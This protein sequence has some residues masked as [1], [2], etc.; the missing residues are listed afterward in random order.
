[1]K[2]IAVVGSYNASETIRVSRIP[3]PGETVMGTGYS[4]GPGGKGSNQAVAARRLDGEVRFV[5]CVGEDKDGDEALSLWRSEKVVV[6]GVR[7]VGRHTGT[8]LIVVK[9]DT[10]ANIITIDPGA[11]LDLSPGDIAA[12][13]EVIVGCGVVLTQLEISS[14]TAMAAARVGKE[15][16]AL[17]ILNP[18]PALPASE[19]DLTQV[20]VV[21]PNE[22]EFRLLAGTD[23]L[24]GG[25]T[26]LLKKGPQT[27]I[28]TLGERGAYVATRK[29][30]YVVPAPRVTSVDETGAG[31]AFNGALAVALSEGEDMEEA[32]WFANVAG[33]LTVTKEEVI[34]ALPR[35]EEV[36]ELRRSAVPP[37]RF[38]KEAA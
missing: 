11:N 27:V 14:E 35:V 34:P 19:L 22:Q 29:R 32:V 23:S 6:K 30:S 1:V 28:V 20:D 15:E 7:R 17:I 16:G 24:E 5:G 9:E 21:T 18:A 31:D 3:R 26:A 37:P 12:S 13:R 4:R 33:A 10:G 36:E 38:R 25:S 8:A 2:P